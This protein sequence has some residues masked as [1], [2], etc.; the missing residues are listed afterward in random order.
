MNKNHMELQESN[1]FMNKV[2]FLDGIQRKE[3]LP[4][5]EILSRLTVNKSDNVLDVGA[6]SGFL[7][8][9]AAK[10]VNETVYALDIDPRMLEVIQTKAHDLNIGNIK[11]LQGSIDY[12]PLPAE[13]MDIVLAS[14]ILHEVGPLPMVIGQISGVLKTGGQFLCLEYEKDEKFI[15]GPPMSIRIKS[16]EL[17]EELIKAGFRVIRKEFPQGPIYIIVAEKQEVLKSE[18]SK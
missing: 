15:Q 17:E 9:P 8:I 2:A 3:L 18:N 6:G 10:M 12:I 4:P 11:L 13:S 16:S 7:T 14:L 5:E 1:K